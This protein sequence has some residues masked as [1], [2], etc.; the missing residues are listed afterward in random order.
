M[1]QPH[2][3]YAETCQ[4]LNVGVAAPPVMRPMPRVRDCHDWR[5]TIRV[6][7]CR[8][9]TLLIKNQNP[10]VQMAWEKWC[11]IVA[12]MIITSSFHIAPDVVV[13]GGGLSKIAGVIDDLAIAVDKRALA[14]VKRP[15]IVLAEA[16]MP[17]VRAVRPMPPI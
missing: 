3:R 10:S 6:K 17:V 14:N 2:C 1:S 5:C 7:R 15:K 9:W 11:E 8:L 12:E 16:E 4:S 13:L